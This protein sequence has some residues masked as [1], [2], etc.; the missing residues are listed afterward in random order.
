M[1]AIQ[2][3]RKMKITIG[4]LTSIFKGGTLSHVAGFL[5]GGGARAGEGQRGHAFVRF[6]ELPEYHSTI[7]TIHSLYKLLPLICVQHI[8]QNKLTKGVDGNVLPEC[9]YFLSIDS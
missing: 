2:L 6:P 8:I 5:L 4:N 9:K 7:L 3:N 1:K